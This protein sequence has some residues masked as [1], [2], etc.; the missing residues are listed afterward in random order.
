M[1][2]TPKISVVSKSKIKIEIF[3]VNMEGF[4]ATGKIKIE[5]NKTVLYDY[6]NMLKINGNGGL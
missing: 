2:T 4:A 3:S 5:I 1:S 6:M